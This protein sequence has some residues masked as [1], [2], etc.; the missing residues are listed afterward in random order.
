MTDRKE[1]WIVDFMKEN[2]L[3]LGVAESC[4]GGMLSSRLIDIP[5]IS[6]VY[7]A[8]LVTY[9]NEAKQSLLGVSKE[10]LKLHG[11]VSEE[12]AKEMVEGTLRVTGA[13]YAVSITGIAGPGGGTE[14]KPVGLVYI[15]CGNK[16]E[17]T[18]KR[19]LFGGDRS[20]VREAST[21]TALQMLKDELLKFCCEPLDGT[22]V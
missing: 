2:N 21:E 22:V 18:V 12:T 1:Q 14:E 15:A 8:G 13:D 10:T 7:R 17:I 11:A 3:T 20:K 5:G 19:N 16:D 6:D 4:S 9:S